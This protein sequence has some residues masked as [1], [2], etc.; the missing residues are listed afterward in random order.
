VRAGLSIASAALSAA[1]A[2]VLGAAP[3]AR[4]GPPVPRAAPAAVADDAAVLGDPGAEPAVRAAAARRLLSSDDAAARVAVA[5]LL[6]APPAPPPEGQAILLVEI[7]RLPSASPALAQPLAAMLAGSTSG[8]LSARV[9]AALG[10]VRTRD[11]VRALIDHAAA[12]QVP[13]VRDAAI[14]A[15]VR[16]TGRSDLGASPARWAEWFASVQFLTEPDWQRTLAQGLADAAD[17]AARERDLA[18]ARLAEVNAQ[19]Y[20]DTPPGEARWAFI[21]SLLRD[22]LARVRRQGVNFVRTELANAR[23]PVPAVGAAAVGL[24][25]DPLP[26]LRREGAELVESMSP[27][28]AD[29]AI[30]EAL[31]GEADESVA[32][33]LLRASRRYPSAAVKPVVLQ[34]LDRGGASPRSSAE[35][36]LRAAVSAVAALVEG[37]IPLTSEEAAGVVRRLRSVDAASLTVAGLRLL[38]TLGDEHDRAAIAG[39]LSSDSGP[40]RAGAAAALV[41]I[42]GSLEALLSAAA[43]DEN[44]FV[45]AARALALHRPTVE[46]FQQALWLPVASLQQR[47]DSLVALAAG[48][49]P[50]DLVAA[51][52]LTD[53]LVL[54][55]RMLSRV[56]GLPLRRPLV[57]PAGHAGDRNGTPEPSLVAAI[58]MLAQTRLDLRQPAGALACLDALA[59]VADDIDQTLRA[60]LAIVALLWLNRI[61]EAAALPAVAAAWLEGLE[62]TVASGLPHAGDILVALRARFDRDLT[63]VQAQRL[64]SIEARLAE[65]MDNGAG[66]SPAAARSPDL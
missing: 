32:A 3:A 23:A 38:A 48:L 46:G 18:V 22:D 6:V 8:D 64:R 7:A 41:P 40:V 16:L 2:G 45:H 31:L 9:C 60:S 12:A 21:A 19:R 13:A 55:D 58:L 17:R 20:L 24:L 34:W 1:I 66:R 25:K 54:R 57:A 51:A 47:R 65:P 5:G 10:S 30:L 37:G 52:G 36:L 15:L 39:L 14:A 11:A 42:A 61:D 63:P 29:R 59:P 33:A 35:P 26:D 28:G 49:D 44:L 43:Q 62:R 27:E 53:D 56:L 50:R 4:A